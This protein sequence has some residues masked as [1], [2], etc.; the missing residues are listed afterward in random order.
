MKLT[1]KDFETIQDA[2]D[3]LYETGNGMSDRER[4]A[5]SKRVQSAEDAI[6]AIG[7]Q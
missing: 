2:L 5:L 7:V 4:I 3:L 1:Q 6:I